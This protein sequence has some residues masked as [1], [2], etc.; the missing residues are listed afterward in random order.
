MVHRRIVRNFKTKKAVC[1]GSYD[2]YLS[3]AMCFHEGGGPLEIVVIEREVEG[4]F[5]RDKN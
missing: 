2:R 5:V 4:N 1:F 3:C